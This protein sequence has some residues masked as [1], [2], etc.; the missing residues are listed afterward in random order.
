MSADP[1][2]TGAPMIEV[3]G[4]TKRYGRQVAVQDVSFTVGA[5]EVVGLL[6]PNGAGK[7]TIL[8]VLAC[9]LP[10]SSGTVRVA[11]RDVFH[12][13]D[14]V[15]RQ[16]GYMPENNPLY[17]DL[18]V[19][20]YLRFRARLKGLRGAAGRRRVDAVL[21]QCGLTDVAGKIIGTLSK[22]YRQRVGLADALVHE[23]RLILLDEPTIGLDPH[24]L[25]A[26][27]AMIR[28]LARERTILI[29][30][31]I[32]PEIEATCGRVLILFAGR[33]L[34]ADTPANLRRRLSAGGE[35]V[36]EIA[37]PPAELHA[38]WAAHPDVARFECAP[39]DDGYVR[40]VLMPRAETDLRPAVFALA[41]EHGWRVRELTRRQQTLEEIFLRL[42][43]PEPEAEE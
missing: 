39:A 30:S 2:Q 28:A 21:E 17:P 19:R 16:I 1:P 37:A 12:E 3:C 20:E 4:L 27:R 29:S 34:A 14:A 40:C 36:C 10:A 25:R 7:S 35:V 5:G 32:L 33:I 43:R 6:G 26:V 42:T 38:C 11:G 18:R 9:Y 23:P 13:A 41:V 31:H 15:R 8:R 22:G 24:Q